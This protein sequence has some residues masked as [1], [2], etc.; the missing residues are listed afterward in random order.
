MSLNETFYAAVATAELGM[1]D[2]MLDAGGE[3]ED[4]HAYGAML[5]EDE[6]VEARSCES[7]LEAL[8][9]LCDE[10]EVMVEEGGGELSDARRKMWSA[11]TWLTDEMQMISDVSMGLTTLFLSGEIRAESMI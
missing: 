1:P 7:A 10:V 3:I 9:M 6:F 4:T 2:S 11:E 5:L 8:E